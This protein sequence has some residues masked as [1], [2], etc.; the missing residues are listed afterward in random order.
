LKLT[1]PSLPLAIE[2]LRPRQRGLD[3][4]IATLSRMKLNA[5]PH[6][7]SEAFESTLPVIETISFATANEKLRKGES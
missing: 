2:I 6:P 5:F 7:S 1:H 3:V 4:F